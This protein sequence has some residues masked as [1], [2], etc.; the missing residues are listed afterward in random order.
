MRDGK[1][2]TKK[3]AR[4]CCTRCN[5]LPIESLKTTVRTC[6]YNPSHLFWRQRSFRRAIASTVN[7]PRRSSGVRLA[8]TDPSGERQRA[9]STPQQWGPP[10]LHRP[11]RRAIARLRSHRVFRRGNIP[12]PQTKTKKEGD[13]NSPLEDYKN[14]HGATAPRCQ[15]CMMYLTEGKQKMGNIHVGKK[16]KRAR[17]VEEIVY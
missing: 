4:R 2:S 8:Y 12:F 17:R 14:S 10:S 3:N 13:L 11:F 6:T 7:R 16:K 1:N 5:Y 9:P 15:Y